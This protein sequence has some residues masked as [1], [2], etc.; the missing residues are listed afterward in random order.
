MINWYEIDTVLLDMDGTLLDLYFDNY[1]WQEFLPMKWG[2]LNG[3]DPSSAKSRLLPHFR[4]IEGT[5]SWY[6]LDYWTDYLNM[7]ILTLNLEIEHL[8][9][10]R[11][12]V[13][14]FLEYVAGTGKPMA[15][16]TNAHGRLIELKFRNTGIGVYFDY[17]FCAHEFGVAKE[18]SGFWAELQR[19]FPFNPNRTLL[20][21]DNLSVLGSARDYGIRHLLAIAQPDSSMPAR[22]IPDFRAVNSFRDLFQES[23]Q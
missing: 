8:I 16:V 19:R 7:D 6:C 12:H 5:L 9:K 22:D 2:Q 10:T 1:F 15:L 17:V 13:D 18:E 14:E 21:D 20:I 11:P 4:Q 3:L 23:R